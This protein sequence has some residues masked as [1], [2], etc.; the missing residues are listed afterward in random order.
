MDQS[1]FM[2]SSYICFSFH[3][4]DECS[5]LDKD[6]RVLVRQEDG[7]MCFAVYVGDGVWYD[8]GSL[9]Y[10]GGISGKIDDIVEFAI[11]D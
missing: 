8:E 1:N 5:K 6:T 9:I 4:V 11:I 7:Y 10:A 2:C 3:P